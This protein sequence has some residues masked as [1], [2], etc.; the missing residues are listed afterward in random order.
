MKNYL[1]KIAVLI[2]VILPI[3][4][5]KKFLNEKSVQSLAT[6][7]TLSDLE[8]ILNSDLINKA[9]NMTNGGSDEYYYLYADWLSR[10]ELPKN[11]YIWDAA[12]NDFNDWRELYIAAFYANT[13]LLNL[14][15]IDANGEQQ[16]WNRIKGAALFYR[17]L[18][19]YRVAQLYAPQYDAATAGTDPG[20]VLRLKADFNEVSVRSTVQQTYD[21]I[22]GDLQTSLDLLGDDLP[23]T[24]LTK[25]FPTKTAAYGL[26]A[27]VSLQKNDYT[28]AK[29]YAQAC[30]QRYSLLLDY[31]DATKVSPAAAAPFK[32]LNDEVIFYSNNDFSP[33][34]NSRAKFD[35][36]LYN[37]FAATDIRKTAFFSKN[38]DGTWRFKGSYNEGNVNLF[39]G[40]ATDEMYLIRAE[41]LAR[42]GN[43]NAAMQDLNTLLSKRYTTASFT[44]W[45]ASSS[46]EA[47]SLIIRERRKELVLRELR[48]PD[49][50]RLNKEQAFATTLTRNL[51]GQLHTLPPNDLRYTLLIP[52]EI[53][54]MVD[55]A[56]NPR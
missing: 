55:L 28:K 33:A 12:L 40:I 41:C 31:N 22:T 38:T 20:I 3:S 44:P 2:V 26:L 50:R 17:A 21:Q 46:A 9:S 32:M 15:T 43:T 37:L 8:A 24:V 34:S 53:L 36:T 45:V 52:I 42:E 49:L 56:Q 4:S 27:R 19:F 13:V 51:N 18:A 16:R 25:T 14:N 35:T 10:S 6:P 5:C 23:N 39:C 30:L 48:W 54:R 47:L 29:E 11:G 1:I 7:G